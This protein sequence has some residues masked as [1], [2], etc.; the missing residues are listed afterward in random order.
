MANNVFKLEKMQFNM[1]IN[2]FKS[3]DTIRLKISKIV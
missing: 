2:K 3:K 1:K